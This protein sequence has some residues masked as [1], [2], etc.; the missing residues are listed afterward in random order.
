M[1]KKEQWQIN[2]RF[3]VSSIEGTQNIKRMKES[4][5]SKRKDRKTGLRGQNK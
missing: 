5:I 4:G 2:N 3:R 1:A